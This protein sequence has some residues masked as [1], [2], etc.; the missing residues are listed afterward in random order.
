MLFITVYPLIEQ[1]L[2]IW[3]LHT[4]GQ[5]QD[6]GQVTLTCIQFIEKIIQ[7]RK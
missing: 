1:I 5:I 7:I 6:D 3:P 4:Q 2:L